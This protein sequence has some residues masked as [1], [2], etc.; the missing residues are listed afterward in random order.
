MFNRSGAGVLESH[1]YTI[2]AESGCNSTLVPGS[3]TS[4]PVSISS[5]AGSG[6]SVP[7]SATNTT[8]SL[9]ASSYP[10]TRQ[11]QPFSR[12]SLNRAIQR[13]MNPWDRSARKDY[14]DDMNFG[15]GGGEWNLYTDFS[16][17]WPSPLEAQPRRRSRLDNHQAIWQQREQGRWFGS[18][19]RRGDYRNFEARP[20]I[21]ISTS[22][23][24]EEQLWR[25]GFNDSHNISQQNNRNRDKMHRSSAFRDHGRGDNSWQNLARHFG[26]GHFHREDVNSAVEE[27]SSSGG[28]LGTAQADSSVLDDSS[29]SGTSRKRPRSLDRGG[30]LSKTS[31]ADSSP[32]SSIFLRPNSVRAS[33]LTNLSERDADKP[34]STSKQAKAHKGR[35]ISG[36]GAKSTAG[37]TPKFG[38]LG[39]KKKHASQ[40]HKTP[41]VTDTAAKSDGN[42][43]ETAGEGV[44]E[45]AERMCQELREKRQQAGQVR[46]SSSALRIAE[47]RGAL[48]TSERR[49]HQAHKSFL[50]GYMSDSSAPNTGPAVGSSTMSTVQK[51][52]FSSSTSSEPPNKAKPV[53]SC[54]SEDVVASSALSSSGSSQVSDIDRI[55]RTIE[56]SVIAEGRV[57]RST[58]RERSLSGNYSPST[59][60][61]SSVTQS[62]G[63]SSSSAVS[64]PPL[65][66]SKDALARMVKA[67][68]SRNQRLQLARILRQHTAP[69]VTRPRRITLA[70]LYNTT[71]EDDGDSIGDVLKNISGLEAMGECPELKNIKLEDLTNEDK[72][73]IAQL[74]EDVDSTGKDSEVSSGEIRDEFTVA[75]SQLSKNTRI[76]R[77]RS[78][79]LDRDRKEVTPTEQPR[80]GSQQR[81]QSV[82]P[83]PSRPLSLDDLNTEERQRYTTPPPSASPAR[84]QSPAQ[85][86]SA[87]SSSPVR[88]AAVRP[89]SPEKSTR[90]TE[91]CSGRAEVNSDDLDKLDT[92]YHNTEKASPEHRLRP[93]RHVPMEVTETTEPDVPI[94][95]GRFHSEKDFEVSGLCHLCLIL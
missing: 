51:K 49:F 93:S 68:Q 38:G 61:S 87:Q 40:K 39:V 62:A 2:S 44:L 43:R 52:H 21:D 9:S 4:V 77:S 57:G 29:S 22:S 37:P 10:Q 36:K 24:H 12:M 27:L 46:A 42:G 69:A 55:R 54:S 23:T 1:N 66:L 45:R 25:S 85:R 8:V 94:S 15:Y 72:L 76:S 71:E 3:S 75:R 83:S 41:K 47:L 60:V 86:P 26:Q 34:D 28:S 88:P 58:A 18:G 90:A 73:R 32:N 31:R 53:T 6:T 78:G 91:N 81:L 35:E 82:S 67:P 50:R 5:V 79:S 48:N 20:E 19:H 95:A 11:Q 13:N 56:S 84:S 64:K 65:P 80:P 74:I 16:Q 17:D 63:V 89:L 7:H 92:N 33:S 14:F 59:S 30:Q 70:G